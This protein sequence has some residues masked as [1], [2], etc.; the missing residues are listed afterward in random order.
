MTE[1]NTRE[2]ATRL[3]LDAAREVPLTEIWNELG[4][5]G[6]QPG[7]QRDRLAEEIDE[8]TVEAEITITFPEASGS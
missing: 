4:G 8:L 5:H 1:V 7:R 2:I 6:V 3:M